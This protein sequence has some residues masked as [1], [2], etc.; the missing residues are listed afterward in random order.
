MTRVCATE[1]GRSRLIDAVMS[2]VLGILT[3]AAFSCS[4]EDVALRIDLFFGLRAVGAGVLLYAL[5]RLARNV[6]SW[7]AGSSRFDTLVR[8]AVDSRRWPAGI[9]IVA[10]ILLLCWAPYLVCAFPGNIYMDTSVQMDW[11]MRFVDTGNPHSISLHHPLVETMLFGWVMSTALQATGSFQV[12]IF[13]LVVA[14]ALCTALTFSLL[15]SFARRRWQSSSMVIVL[16]FAFVALVPLVPIIIC[17]VSKDSFFSWVY[18]LFLIGLID[19]IRSCRDQ[20]KPWGV[21]IALLAVGSVLSCVTKNFGIYVVVLALLALL[22]FGKVG[23]AVRLKV[24]VPVLAGTLIAAALVFVAPKAIG[25]Y[26]GGMEEPLSLPF[27]QTA[28]TLIRHGDEMPDDEKEV[29][30]KVIDVETIA[31]DYEPASA[32][33]VKGYSPKGAR[34][35]YVRYMVVWAK[36]GL[37]YPADYLDAF[38]G[39][40]APLFSPAPLKQIFDSG[41]TT[42][43]DYFPDGYDEKSPFN[44]EASAG[45]RA[46]Y[47]WLIDVPILNVLFMA[48]SYGV[49]VPCLLL[50]VVLSSSQKRAWIPVLVAVFVSLA[51][52][53]LSPIVAGHT[54]STRYFMPFVYSVP[55]LLVLCT[56]LLRSSYLTQIEES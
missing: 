39:L 53:M 10:G 4:G 9:G 47:L 1:T 3:S 17:T 5:F 48:F 2:A 23:K 40:E 28:L 29:I 8:L 16:M 11:Y 13:I 22:L 30:D 56:S 36:Q 54:E 38:L 27:Q 51:G 33:G 44:T 21:S 46:F 41:W 26:S 49:F 6:L 32:D 18:V 35:D 37:R 45:L 52:L 43:S 50:G 12:G 19:I 7:V 55:V 42:N 34:N 15:I 31:D 25:F 24:V 20:E 14:Q